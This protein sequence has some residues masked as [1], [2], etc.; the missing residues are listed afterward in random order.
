MGICISTGSACDSLNTHVSHV[1]KA[2][3]MPDEYVNGT[4]RISLGK[5]NTTDDVDA[6]FNIINKIMIL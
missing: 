6:I 2:L 3:G 1:I 5:D 4:V